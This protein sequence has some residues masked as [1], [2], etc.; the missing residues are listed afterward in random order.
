MCTRADI[1]ITSPFFH[2]GSAPSEAV[3]AGGDKSSPAEGKK[4]FASSW[5]AKEAGAVDGTEA[6]FLSNL[7]TAQNYN[8]NVTHG[9]C[10][11]YHLLHPSCLVRLMHI[12]CIIEQDIGYARRYMQTIVSLSMA[13][14]V[15]M[16]I[17]LSSCVTLS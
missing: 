11:P 16:N 14:M 1:D 8:I 4:K 6:D 17:A 13:A 5:D 2:S 3:E 12:S 10:Y 7:G 15:D 9:T